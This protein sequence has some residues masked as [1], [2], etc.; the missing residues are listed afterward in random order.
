MMKTIVLQRSLGIEFI[1]SK[2]FIF[3]IGVKGDRERPP[4][5]VHW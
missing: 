5:Y 2:S 1:K 3:S 4:F